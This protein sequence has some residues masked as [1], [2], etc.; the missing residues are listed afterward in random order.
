VVLLHGRRKARFN[1]YSG[2]TSGWQSKS[3]TVDYWGF[4]RSMSVSNYGSLGVPA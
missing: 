2:S 3:W 1:S 4:Q